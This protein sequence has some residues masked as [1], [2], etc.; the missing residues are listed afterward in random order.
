MICLCQAHHNIF[1]M[2]VEK[3]VFEHSFLGRME[4]IQGT[5]CLLEAIVPFCHNFTNKSSAAGA[6]KVI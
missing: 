6:F 3:F 5:N 1:Q 2:T 4:T